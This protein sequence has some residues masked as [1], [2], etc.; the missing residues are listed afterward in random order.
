MK[1][2]FSTF[3][4]IKEVAKCDGH[5]TTR[6]TLEVPHRMMLCDLSIKDLVSIRD[7]AERL[8][9]NRGIQDRTIY[10]GTLECVEEVENDETNSETTS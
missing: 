7:Q 3:K 9:Q 5:H 10:L 1:A 4:H 8:I 6:V 2:R